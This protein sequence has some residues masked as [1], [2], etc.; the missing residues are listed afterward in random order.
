MINKTIIISAGM[1]ILLGLSVL[2]V[3]SEVLAYLPGHWW[4]RLVRPVEGLL[5]AA[6][7]V[8][9][10]R[11][12]RRLGVVFYKI[13]ALPL[14][15]SAGL[16]LENVLFG[17]F[18]FPFPVP[19]DI[20]IYTVVSLLRFL[21]GLAGGFA[22]AMLIVHAVG[23]CTGYAQPFSLRRGFLLLLTVFVGLWLALGII[24]ILHIYS[25]P[26][27]R[28]EFFLLPMEAVLMAIIYLDGIRMARN[29]LHKAQSRVLNGLVLVMG[30][31]VVAIVAGFFP[32]LYPHFFSTPVAVYYNY[33]TMVISFAVPVILVYVLADCGREC[34]ESEN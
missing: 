12:Y 13:L 21:I 34:H 20:T 14:F 22:I 17:L 7:G 5:F 29:R 9:A 28:V 23:V 19:G 16:L 26:M 30:L 32:W 4:V 1:V 3:E 8:L 11:C 18:Q 15:L 6:A 24:N 27:V 31:K 33:V 10:W 25:A 2:V